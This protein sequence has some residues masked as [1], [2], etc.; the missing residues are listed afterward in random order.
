M[1]VIIL[2]HLKMKY[3][4]Y[5]IHYIDR[6]ILQKKCM[7]DLLMYKKMEMIFMNSKNSKTSEKHLLRLLLTDKLNLKNYNKNIAFVILSIFYTFKNIKNSYDNNKFK[8]YAP[9]WDQTFNLPDGSY[10]VQD[11]QDYFEFIIKNHESLPDNPPLKI[12]PNRLVNRIDFKIKS[13][14]KLEALSENTKKLLG[15]ASNIV[16]TDKNS[17][18]APNIQTVEIGLVHYNLVENHYQSSSKVLFVF[19]S[20]KQYGMLINI[21]PHTLIMLITQHSEFSSLDVW[22]TGQNG[23]PL[24]IEDN[25]NL[26]LVIG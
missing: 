20:D 19:V 21:K 13:G 25:I 5:L 15:L 14:Y 7:I 17:E 16:D 3:G 4:K 8:I 9:T 23:K 11:I 2:K 18:S 12:Y 26:T 1:Q 10:S 6:I 24:Q 22:F